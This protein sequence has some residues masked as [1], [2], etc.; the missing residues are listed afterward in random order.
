M[1]S[2]SAEQ[3]IFTRISSFYH[4]HT[5]SKDITTYDPLLFSTMNRDVIKLRDWLIS[6]N[7]R[8]ACMESTGKYWIPIGNTLES[9]IKLNL[10][11]PK[12]AKTV[13]GKITDKKDSK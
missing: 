1:F 6:H 10:A 3:W 12:Y 9:E 11:Y 8:L 4:T 5:D 7:C 2:K 13:K